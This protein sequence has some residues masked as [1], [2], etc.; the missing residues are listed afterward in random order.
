MRWYG[1]RPGKFDVRIVKSKFRALLDLNPAHK[2]SKDGKQV[3]IV[4]VASI[5]NVVSTVNA[6]SI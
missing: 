3:S 1:G 6:V 2:R 4:D 5:V